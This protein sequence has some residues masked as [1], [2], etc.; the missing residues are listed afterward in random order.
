MSL[1]QDDEDE[2]VRYRIEPWITISIY[3]F[4]LRTS[5]FSSISVPFLSSDWCAWSVCVCVQTHHQEPLPGN[6][7]GRCVNITT[8]LKRK[9]KTSNLFLWFSK[10]R[11]K[12]RRQ[13]AQSPH[14]RGASNCKSWPT[15]CSG[16]SHT[17]K[18][19]ADAKTTSTFL[20]PERIV[21]CV[22]PPQKISRKKWRQSTRLRPC[23]TLNSLSDCTFRLFHWL[24]DVILHAASR[25]IF[26]SPLLQRSL[27]VWTIF[28]VRSHFRMSA[29]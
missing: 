3:F 25:G 12:K 19:L 2:V 26:S 10:C 11:K 5:D 27:S 23:K 9:R 18:W 16:W 4:R 22:Q 6:P 7:T 15:G 14:P 17:P 8:T 21:G 20:H 13:A 29:T 1:Y 28:M 24:C